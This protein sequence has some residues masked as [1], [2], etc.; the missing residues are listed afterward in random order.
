[1]LFEA[2]KIVES[3]LFRPNQISIDTVVRTC[4]QARTSQLSAL[5]SKTLDS[6]TAA[7]VHETA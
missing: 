4:G 5:A 2:G 6:L 1:M 7:K 3:L